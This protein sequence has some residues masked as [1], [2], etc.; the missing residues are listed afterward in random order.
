LRFTLIK[1][2]KKDKSMS[3]ILNGF[4][5]FSISYLI[6]DI[7]VKYNSFGVFEGNIRVTLFGNADEF[8]DPISKSSFLEFIHM[9]IFFI[10]MILLTLSAVYIRLS[11]GKFYS[12]LVV[13]ASMI[14]SILSL[15]TL[16]LSYFASDKF[17]Q[18]YVASFFLWHFLAIYMT[19]HS[20]WSMNFD[21]SV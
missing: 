8:I 4:L 1:D 19:S 15:I 9:E 12:V 10:M 2:L 18:V 13:N 20:L 11:K 16:A 14:S 3:V 21:K 5:L 6:S 17:I 7:F